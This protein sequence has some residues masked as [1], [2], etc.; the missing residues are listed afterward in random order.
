MGMYSTFLGQEIEVINKNELLKIKRENKDNEIY[1]II[2]DDGEID[3]LGWDDN[4]IEGYWYDETTKILREIAPCIVGEV[5]FLYEEGYQ[6]K[7]IFK[8]GKVFTT[9]QKDATFYEPEEL[10]EVRK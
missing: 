6:F 10:K 8:E 3:F 9:K 2:E 4:K 7:I 1:E 5:T